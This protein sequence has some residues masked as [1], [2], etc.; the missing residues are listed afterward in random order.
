MQTPLFLP[1]YCCDQSVNASLQTSGIL[2]QFVSLYNLNIVRP[3]S[4]YAKI[5]LAHYYAIDVFKGNWHPQA[6]VYFKH[7]LVQ[8]GSAM[9]MPNLQL[10]HSV[11]SVCT[12]L[13][14]F[15]TSTSIDELTGFLLCWSNLFDLHMAQGKCIFVVSAMANLTLTSIKFVGVLLVT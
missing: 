4:Q 13:N 3:D 10:S 12:V 6:N 8:Y 7:F 14:L 5:A 9:D 2:H 1:S 11:F 15:S